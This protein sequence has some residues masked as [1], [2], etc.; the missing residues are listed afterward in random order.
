MTN[1][2]NVSKYEMKLSRTIWFT[3]YNITQ[4]CN[5]HY[6]LYKIPTPELS[7]LTKSRSDRSVL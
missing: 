7:K 3:K 4:F 6:G 5:A 1:H 2:W